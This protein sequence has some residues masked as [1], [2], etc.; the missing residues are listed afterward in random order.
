M[1]DSENWKEIINTERYSDEM[2]YHRGLGYTQ[3]Y[4]DCLEYFEGKFKN[5]KYYDTLHVR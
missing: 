2:E 3:G 4:K 1:I 5:H